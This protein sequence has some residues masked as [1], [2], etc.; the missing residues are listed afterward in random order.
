MLLVGIPSGISTWQLAR[1]RQ[2]SKG[3]L[4]LLVGGPIFDSIIAFWLF[5]LLGVSG[6]TLW[7]GALCI[8]IISHILVQ[9]LLVPQRLIMWRLAKENIL[10]RKRQ[11]ALLMAGLV[12]ASAIISSSL[13][14]GDSL[15][16]LIHI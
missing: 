14:V 15:L 12:I 8:G 9:P 4:A 5:E 13:V 2:L 11:A 1:A 16:S 7:V 10:R 3:V 6:P